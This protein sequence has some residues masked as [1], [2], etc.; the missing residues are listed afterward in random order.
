MKSYLLEPEVA[1][2]IWETYQNGVKEISNL[3]YKL[4]GWIGNELLESTPCCR[5]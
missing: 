4:E 1:I 2:G 5:P 3:H